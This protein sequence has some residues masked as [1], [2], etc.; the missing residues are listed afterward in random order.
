MCDKLSEWYESEVKQKLCL[1]LVS[2]C[3]DIRRR[4][5][6]LSHK[7][8]RHWN[9]YEA[10]S[11]RSYGPTVPVPFKSSCYYFP[12]AID[13]S[14]MSIGVREMFSIGRLVHPLWYCSSYVA[15]TWICP[16][17]TFARL[18]VVLQLHLPRCLAVCYHLQIEAPINFGRQLL[19]TSQHQRSLLVDRLHSCPLS[20]F[21]QFNQ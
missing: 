14:L 20:L 21:T 19:P 10:E 12:W 5:L 3:V 18:V 16:A 7:H 1:T 8:L 2:S 6:R 9:W 4:V 17:W 11:L 13:L 15:D